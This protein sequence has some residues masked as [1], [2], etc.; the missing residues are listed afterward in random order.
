MRV[1]KRSSVPLPLALGLLALALVPPGAA[2]AQ[3]LPEAGTLVERYVELIGGREGI[4]SR[5]FIR[6][7]GQFQLPAMGV[8]GELEVYQ[9]YPGRNAVRVS[10]P[11]LGEIRSGFDGAVGWSLDP[12]QGPRVMEGRELEQTREEAS[13]ASTLRDPSVV[14]S[15]E[16]VEQVEMNGESCWRV[17]LTW[18]SGRETFDCYSL[19]S[20][21]LIASTSTQESPM[22]SIQVTSLLNDYREFGGFRFPTRM[23]QQ[24]MGQEQ[25]LL[26]TDVAFPPPDESVFALPPEI[27]A[28]TGGGS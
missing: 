17:R 13:F 3:E 28:L 14:A 23:T 18:H 10:I 25:V 6:S 21:L 1:Y 5:P 4:L 15:M 8:S 16:T 22:G 2:R 26:I 27:R 9:G 20:G 19:E 11:G 24:M 12:M 7:T